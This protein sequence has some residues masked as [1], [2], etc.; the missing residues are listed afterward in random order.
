MKRNIIILMVLMIVPLVSAEYLTVEM[1]APTPANNSNVSGT[2]FYVYWK[3]TSDFSSNLTDAFTCDIQQNGG[4][5]G[6]TAYNNTIMNAIIYTDM[7][8]TLEI[9]C[10]PFFPYVPI[11]TTG[12]YTWNFIGWQPEY[13][14][15]DIAPVAVDG[16]VKIIISVTQ[17]VF[18]P[19]IILILIFLVGQLKKV[20]R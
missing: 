15:D 5:R 14:A 19:V 3:V 8:N 7:G 16:I 11:N 20:K 6:A 10:H 18:L 13:S 9:V 2:Y 4:T 1:V 12:L 17:V